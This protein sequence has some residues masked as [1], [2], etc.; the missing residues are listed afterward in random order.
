MGE[1]DSRY[2]S[3][4]DALLDLMQIDANADDEE[5]AHREAD[6]VLLRLIRAQGAPTSKYDEVANFYEQIS[7]HFWYA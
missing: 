3:A 5:M 2:Y 1:R 7:K 4:T 6:K